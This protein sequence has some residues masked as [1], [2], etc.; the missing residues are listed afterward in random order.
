[1]HFARREIDG[2]IEYRVSWEGYDDVTWEPEEHLQQCPDK[3]AAFYSN[4]DTE[5][6]GCA[7]GHHKDV[8]RC[9]RP[10]YHIGQDE[11]IFKA[12]SYSSNQWSIN[13]VRGLRKKTEG[14]GDM[15]SAMQ[16]EIRGFGFPMNGDELK[17][18]NDFR[19]KRGRAE[20]DTSPGVRFLNYGKGRDG[21]WDYDHFARQVGDLMDAMEV[22]HPDWQ[23]LL[24]VDWSS[25]HAKH[26]EG[27]LNTNAMNV[28]YGGGQKVPR[29]TTTPVDPDEAKRYLGRY[30]PQLKPGE[31]QF[32]EFR[33]GDDPPFNDPNAPKYDAA[34]GLDGNKRNRKGQ[35]VVKEGYVG[36]AKGLA[37]I[38]W[39]RGLYRPADNGK[40]MHGNRKVDP[41]EDAEML[42]WSLRHVLSNCFDF[43]NEKSALTRLVE[44]RGR[45]LR[46]CVKGHPELAGVGIEYSWGKAK[47][48]FRRDVNDRKPK[49]LRRN[50]IK[51]FSREDECLP[52]ARVRKFAR[53]TRAYRRAYREGKPNAHADVEKLV[54]KFKSHRSADTFDTAFC[55]AD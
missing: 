32:F 22:L 10:I 35:R 54:G 4:P 23:M 49:H 6:Q 50:V 42:S 17:R 15:V 8:C 28:G 13:G 14:P 33:E 31:T 30:N 19:K 16:D 5:A 24:E 11:C 55:Y 3:L 38:A 53:K 1:M 48:K 37:Q 46:M 44:S 45:I 34:P 9:G 21:Y 47:Q 7:Y 29:E 51:C 39:E 25:G 40:S 27:A 36:K 43:A 2:L 26:L 12:F 20:L 52:V 18:V 41:N